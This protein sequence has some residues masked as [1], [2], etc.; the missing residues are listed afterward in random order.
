M[1]LKRVHLKASTALLT[2]GIVCAWCSDASASALI[3]SYVKL[4][5]GPGSSAGEFRVDDGQ[6]ISGGTGLFNTFCV[7]RQEVISYNTSYRVSLGNVP[8][9]NPNNVNI[10]SGDG[11]KA[12]ALYREFLRGKPTSAAGSA[13]GTILG[14]KYDF[15]KAGNVAN[16]DA[17]LL[18]KA[19][20]YYMGQ[21]TAGTTLYSTL[22]KAIKNNVYIAAAEAQIALIQGNVAYYGGVQV[23]NLF[24][25]SWNSAGTV[26][27]DSSRNVNAQDQLYYDPNGPQFPTNPVPEPSTLVLFGLG[28]FGAAWKRRSGLSVAGV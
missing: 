25:G 8:I 3:S 9:S 6:K 21:N 14:V 22:A 1:V 19:I 23:M 27:T 24:K 13:T 7:Q 5:N 18:Q 20:W 12:A 16:S 26:W 28:L 2:L 10:T 11:V 15:S 17:D 4:Q